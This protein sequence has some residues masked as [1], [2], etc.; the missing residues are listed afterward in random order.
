MHVRLRQASPLALIPLEPVAA[1]SCR[2]LWSRAAQPG[3]AIPSCGAPSGSRKERAEMCPVSHGLEK[4]VAGLHKVEG[5]WEFAKA[6]SGG[7]GTPS[8]PPRAPLIYC[9]GRAPPPPGPLPQ[10]ARPSRSPSP[11]TPPPHSRGGEFKPR[12]RDPSW[13]NERRR[14]VKSGSNR[15]EAPSAIKTL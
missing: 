11:P 10:G 8:P 2:R 9:L 5:T 12:P 4:W 13:A 14:E 3:L 15:S 1:A 7:S 6:S